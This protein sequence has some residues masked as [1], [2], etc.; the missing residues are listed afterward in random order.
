MQERD[1]FD[2]AD[3]ALALIRDVVAQPQPLIL[4]VKPELSVDAPQ[5]EL[6]NETIFRASASAHDLELGSEGNFTI[7][8]DVEGLLTG[9]DVDNDLPKLTVSGLA[10]KHS[11]CHGLP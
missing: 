8:G 6:E 5:A 7:G 4:D 1:Q 10:R 3:P 2:V 11:T 9:V